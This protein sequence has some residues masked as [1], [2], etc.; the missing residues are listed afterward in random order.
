MTLLRS[1]RIVAMLVATAI[2]PASFPAT[3]FAQK[4]AT[5]SK[6]DL[7]KAKKA[8]FEGIALEEQ[9]KW[10][11]ALKRFELVAKVRMTPQVRFHI[12]LCKE[13]L[14]M[15]IEAMHDF[16]LAEADAKSEKVETVMKEA[17]EHAAAIKPRIPKLTIK[18]PSDVEGLAVTL[19]G[20]P[21]DPK[22]SE[23]T[24]V[25]PGTH[26]IEATAEKRKP[27][28]QEVT[29][30]D[31]E[32]KSILVKVP[33]LG[34]GEPKEEPPPKEEP[35]PQ[36]K[37]SGGPPVAALVVGGIGVVSLIGAGAFYLARSSVKSDLDSACGDDR[38]SCPADKE[39]AISTGRTYTTL[40]NVFA[41]VGVVGVGAGIV[42]YVTAPKDKEQPAATAPATSIRLVPQAPGANVA[43]FS[44]SGVF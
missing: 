34:G 43:G 38:Q 21:I 15:L 36:P 10:D 1:S 2:V 25:N 14:G 42:L 22:G 24:L 19:D 37:P 26:K 29:L 41:I 6:A 13:N 4:A 39:G 44:L 35:T 32:S 3:S 31:G 20:N 16:E 5:T 8:F 40:T 28:S 30:A 11:E 12:A 7:E 27:F 23:E 17:P 18:V 33:P 9:K